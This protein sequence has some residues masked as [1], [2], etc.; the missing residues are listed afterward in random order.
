MLRYLILFLVACDPSTVKMNPGRD[1]MLIF[2]NE[3]LAMNQD[4]AGDDLALPPEDMMAASRPDLR[5]ADLAH[6]V[7]GC[8]IVVNEL[9]L[10]TTKSAS[11]EFIEIFNSCSTSTS[12]KNWSLKYRSAQNNQGTNNPDTEL[13]T[14]LSKTIAAN[15]YLL[16]GG[17]GYTG[18]KDG[19]LLNGLSDTG[20]GVAVIDDKNN[21]VD[22]VA[23]GSANNT[24]NF[25][26]GSVAPAPPQAAPP[27]KVIARVPN[28]RDTDDNGTDFV[29][30]DPTPKAANN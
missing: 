20:G 9:L 28:G 23:Y 26:E 4:L 8:G 13:V 1:G 21:I 17:T 18:S 11:A 3:D 27:G 2:E 10:S 5:G 16:W 22:S 6:T 14:D 12:L 19:T 7:N 30:T 29:V 24:H 15:G 25:L